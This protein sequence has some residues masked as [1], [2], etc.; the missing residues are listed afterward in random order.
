VCHQRPFSSD[1]ARSCAARVL[2]DHFPP[3][4]RLL[5]N[6]IFCN[7]SFERDEDDIRMYGTQTALPPDGRVSEN[8]DEGSDSCATIGPIGGELQ[9][10]MAQCAGKTR[11]LIAS[12]VFTLLN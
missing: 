11:F 3:G 12:L 10:S 5:F 8:K 4:K 7:S 2:K 9:P 1:L 6:V